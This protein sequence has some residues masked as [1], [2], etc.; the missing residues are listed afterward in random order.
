METNG[1]KIIDQ[2]ISAMVDREGKYLTFSPGRRGNTGSE[3]LKVKEI[4]GMMTI[5]PRYRRQPP[6]V[7]GRHQSAG[8]RSSPLSICA[9]NSR[10]TR[11]NIRNEPASS[12]WRSGRVTVRLPWESWSIPYRRCSISKAGRSRITPNFGTR[13]DTAYIPRHGE[14]RPGCENPPRYRPRH[15]QRRNGR[16]QLRL[17]GLIRDS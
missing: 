2:A 3:S 10:W 15:E 9:S 4:I 5:T 1:T 14:I 7:K 6:Y 13:L 12:S 11:R 8:G 17:A 16:P